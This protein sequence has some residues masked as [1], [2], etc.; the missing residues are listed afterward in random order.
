MWSFQKQNSSYVSSAR[1]GI[2]QNLYNTKTGEKLYRYKKIYVAVKRPMSGSHRTVLFLHFPELWLVFFSGGE[3]REN[4]LV[5]PVF[6]NC[7]E[8]KSSEFD[9]LD[10]SRGIMYCSGKSL[11]YRETDIISD[12]KRM[13]TKYYK[14]VYRPNHWHYS[15]QLILGK[16]KEFLGV[17]TFYRI[18]GKENFQY[19]DIFLLDMLKDHLAYRLYRNKQVLSNTVDKMTV[20]EAAEKFALTKREQ[21][22]LKMLLRK[23]GWRQ[24]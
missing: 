23:F 1:C 8:N 3:G 18:L 14:K 4:H 11:V 22:I 24:W 2:Q 13:Q 16:G 9:E 15:L 19:N 6:F 7:S 21:T 5:E 17:V 20:T 10:Y 12:E